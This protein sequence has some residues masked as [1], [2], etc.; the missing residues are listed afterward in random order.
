MV[1]RQLQSVAF[2]CCNRPV[3]KLN[4]CCKDFQ[5]P[6]RKGKIL[7]LRQRE[8]Q[9]LEMKQVNVWFLFTRPIPS[10]ASICF[11]VL[12]I[13]C[14]ARRNKLSLQNVLSIML[15]KTL[16][17]YVH[18]CPSVLFL[19]NY[20]ALGWAKVVAWVQICP[21]SFH[22]AIFGEFSLTWKCDRQVGWTTC[23]V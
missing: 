18:I 21:S 2:I 8:Q 14:N 5:S 20:Y 15:I 16:S 4:S 12:C 22:Y 13:L 7:L 1:N 17:H 11:N 3:N 19:C 6:I 10:N 9:F 23:S